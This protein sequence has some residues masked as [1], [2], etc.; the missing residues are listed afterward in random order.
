[1]AAIIGHDPKNA[2]PGLS[3]SRRC[4]STTGCAALC[5]AVG[6]MTAWLPLP[7]IRRARA[8]ASAAIAV[9]VIGSPPSSAFFFQ[10]VSD[11]R[12]AR[13]LPRAARRLLRFHPLA[14]LILLGCR[15][16]PRQG[17]D[18]GAG[19]RSRVHAGNGGLGAIIPASSGMV[20]G[21][22][23]AP[24]RLTDIGAR[25][26]ALEQV[27]NIRVVRCDEAAW[28]FLGLSWRLQRASSRWRWRQLRCGAPPPRGRRRTPNPTAARVACRLET[29]TDRS[30]VSRTNS[31]AALCR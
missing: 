24:E 15:S 1:M 17:F 13:P 4:G 11:C 23:T 16:D 26:R 8:D 7:E 31:R 30:S 19:S 12:R 20:A 28:R 9:A 21:R 14:A 29:L 2:S 22:R 18:I 6:R 10:Y 25:A 3:G 27:Q 5:G